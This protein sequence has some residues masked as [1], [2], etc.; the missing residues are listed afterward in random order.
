[1]IVII[2]VFAILRAFNVDIAP[3]L[4]G[5][6]LA[7]LVLGFGAQN[8]LRDVLAG[9]FMILEDQF[10]VGDRIDTGFATGRVEAVTL[11]ITTVRDEDGVLWHVPNGQVQRIANLSSRR[12]P[13]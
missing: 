8:L 6:G 13:A 4:A 10:N 11:R 7:G 1:V 5:A 12:A 9:T 3:I 2:T